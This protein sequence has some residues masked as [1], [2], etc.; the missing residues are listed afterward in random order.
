MHSLNFLVKVNKGAKVNI[1]KK[2]IVIGAGNTGMDVIF[3]VYKCGA[4]EVVCIDVQKPAVF[5]QEINHA[6]SLGAER[7]YP[8]FIKEILDDGIL[9]TSG[10]KI[11]ADSVILAIGDI[12]K[13]GLLVDAIGHG[14]ELANILDAKANGQKYTPI[15]KKLVS[16]NSLVTAYFDRVQPADICGGCSDKSRCISCGTCRDCEICNSSCPEKKGFLSSL[17]LGL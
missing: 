15:V 5:K 1:G 14:R 10:E 8:V 17:M 3:G 16:K 13:L 7:R 2:V 12:T 4:K 11:S 9:T 6:K